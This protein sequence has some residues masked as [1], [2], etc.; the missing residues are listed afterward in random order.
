MSTPSS[1]PTAGRG[2]SLLR[3]VLAAVGVL[4]GAPLIGSMLLPWAQVDG[5]VAVDETTAR[6]HDLFDVPAGTDDRAEKVTAEVS[7]LGAVSDLVLTRKRSGLRNP[8]STPADR[9][10]PEDVRAEIRAHVAPWGSVVVVGGV[11]AVLGAVLSLTP[12]LRPVG[13]VTLLSAGAMS[14]VA[15][16]RSLLGSNV[17]PAAT[18][19]YL[20]GNDT[21]VR[22]GTLFVSVTSGP[23]AAVALG[24]AIAILAS[25]LIGAHLAARDRLAQS[26]SSGSGAPPPKRAGTQYSPGG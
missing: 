19:D 14:M 22:P 1:V 12:P 8:Y 21:G 9:A 7:G 26:T 25:A 3:L 10:R 11:L 16:V 18:L 15:A 13:L 17:D 4:A 2:A 24:A 23:G 5:Q 20:I 6:P